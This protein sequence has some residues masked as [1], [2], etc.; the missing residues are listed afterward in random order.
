[1]PNSAKISI[2]VEGWQFQSTSNSI[3]IVFQSVSSTL[4]TPSVGPPGGLLSWSNLDV[5]EK[6]FFSSFFPKGELDGSPTN[7]ASVPSANGSSVTVISPFFEER[8]VIDPSLSVLVDSNN[9]K[10]P[11]GGGHPLKLWL[12]GVVAGSI[13]AAG[14]AVGSMVLYKKH[15]AT[16]MVQRALKK[17]YSGASIL[18][19]KDSG[20]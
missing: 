16:S 14:V 17:T 13:G 18:D 10:S 8:L 5:G 20:L 9:E 11:N 12:V 3:G 19:S 1:L 15:R 7:L 6:S 2:I 4:Y